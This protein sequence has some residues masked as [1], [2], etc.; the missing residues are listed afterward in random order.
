MRSLFWIVV[1]II[2]YGSTFPFSFAM[3]EWNTQNWANWLT[4]VEQR[5]TNGDLLSNLL[6]FIPLGYFAYYYLKAR[7][8]SKFINAIIV[9]SGG[10]LFAF[11][12]QVVQF[13]IP[14]RVPT[15][16]DAL[17][18]LWGIILG[19]AL[20]MLAEWGINQ[21]LR[22]KEHWQQAFMAPLLLII[23]WCL[24]QLFPFFPEF[25]FAN[26]SKS[27]SSL[28]ASPFAVWHLFIFHLMMWW[29]FFVLVS[30]NPWFKLTLWR[31]FSFILGLLLAKLII[32]HN[33]IE[34]HFVLGSVIGFIL[35][36]KVTPMI[37]LTQNESTN[38]KSIKILCSSFVLVFVFTSIYPWFIKM[39][40][41]EFNLW[42]FNAYLKGSLWVNT[43]TFLEKLFVYGAAFY[44]L[45]L[46]FS[47]KIKAFLIGFTLIGV[48]EIMQLFV[49]F[50]R[51]DITDL[52]MF[53]LIAYSLE[54]LAEDE[55]FVSAP[56]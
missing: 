36:D 13:F 2:V 34:W 35:A 20:A 15:V 18:D 4:T 14:S 39:F 52:V 5:T 23:L 27:L 12:L 31:A 11:L 21:N 51:A 17:F 54:K 45:K 46:M 32:A 28:S 3:P 42:P 6:T 40:T 33:P 38:N 8:S 10:F 53:G 48:I 44:F 56:T 25:S 47:E 50:G 41:S 29:C 30:Q 22:L 24:Y 37:S 9:L 16:G 1:A 55:S 26:I 7:I 43:R 19:V 49:S